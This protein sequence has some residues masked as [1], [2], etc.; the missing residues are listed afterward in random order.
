MGSGNPTLVEF[1]LYKNSPYSKWLNY[2]SSPK[3][4]TSEGIKQDCPGTI[5]RQVIC[6][7]EI[8]IQVS[9]LSL[10]KFL[11]ACHRMVDPGVRR[12]IGYLSLVSGRPL[13][14]STVPLPDI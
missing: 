10:K 12:H 7:S 14:G 5:F 2:L 9:D 1:S 4:S 3:G 11:D 6:E 13:S 8:Q